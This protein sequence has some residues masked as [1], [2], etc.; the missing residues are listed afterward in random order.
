[1][2]KRFIK[3]DLPNSLIQSFQRH[4]LPSENLCWEGLWLK[5]GRGRGDAGTRGCGDAGTRGRGDAGTRG[6]GDAGTRGR[7]DA[8]TRGRGDA[9]TRGRVF[10]DVG[11]RAAWGREIGD[12]WEREIGDVGTG[13]WGRGDVKTR[14]RG[15]EIGKLGDVSAVWLSNM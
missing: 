11:R 7:G 8:G 4:Y 3:V 2:Q 14:T 12:A 1:M 13:V 9:G 6:R 5:V 10:G 15:R